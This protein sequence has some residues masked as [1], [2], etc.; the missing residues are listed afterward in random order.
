MKTITVGFS[1]PKK[2]NLFAAA[3]IFLFRT[4]FD[5]VYIKFHSESYEKD[6]IYQASKMIINFMGTNVFNSEND[7]IEEFEVSISDENLK[8][9]IQFAIDN[10]GKSYSVREAIGLGVVRVIKNIYGIT[11]NNPF[12]DG[13][14]KYV[15]SVLVS[16]ILTNFTDK[17]TIGDFQEMAPIDVYNFL[18]TQNNSLKS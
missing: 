9:M 3:I 6:L 18:K 14:N 1:K 11:V 12:K 4:K 15:C 8:S 5:H 17:N 2:M 10:A 13:T 16:Y 7:V